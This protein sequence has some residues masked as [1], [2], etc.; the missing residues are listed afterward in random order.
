[1]RM[2]YRDEVDE[3]DLMLR[4]DV[5]FEEIEEHINLTQLDDDVRAAL[6]LYAWTW[7]ERDGQRQVVRE[8]LTVRG[9]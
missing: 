2:A 3:I 4:D 6:W 5:E 1:M 9:M 8:M 7:Q